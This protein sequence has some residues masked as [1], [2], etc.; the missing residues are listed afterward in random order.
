MFSIKDISDLVRYSMM[1]FNVTMTELSL[2]TGIDV[3]RINKIEL[4]KEMLTENELTKIVDWFRL[5]HKDRVDK[6]YKELR[7]IV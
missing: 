4:G 6:N 7:K 1:E 2:N 5:K 3:L